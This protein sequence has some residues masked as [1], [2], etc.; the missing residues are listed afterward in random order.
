[1]LKYLGLILIVLTCFGIGFYYSLRLKYRYEFLSSFNEFLSTLETNIRYNSADIFSLI[2]SSASESISEY[3]LKRNEKSFQSYWNSCISALPKRLALKK[4][5]YNLLYE[6]GRMLGATDIEG[7]L[8][9]INL[10]KELIKHNINNSD[11]ELKQKSKLSKLLGLFA[12][13]TIALI[14]L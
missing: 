11:K 8:N 7:Q 13:L 2:K 9:H 5:D 14:L 4:D 10:Y 12:G 3:F 1:M 6:F